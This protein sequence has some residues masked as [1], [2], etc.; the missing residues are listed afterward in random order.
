LI[1]NG[2]RQSE[3]TLQ[4]VCAVVPRVVIPV[5]VVWL[6]V[7]GFPRR[8]ESAGIKRYP[9]SS[10]APKGCKDAMQCRTLPDILLRLMTPDRKEILRFTPEFTPALAVTHWNVELT[11]E[12][13][14]QPCTQVNRNRIVDFDPAAFIEMT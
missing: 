8:R 10:R 6:S 11:F 4:K 5:N 7:A 1:G 12:N 2:I 3:N 14:D 13:A 9:K